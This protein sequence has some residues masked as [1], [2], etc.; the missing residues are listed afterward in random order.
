MINPLFRPYVPYKSWVAGAEL[1]NELEIINIRSAISNP[2]GTLLLVIKL[3]KLVESTIA[4]Q[5][6]PSTPMAIN[7]GTFTGS[8]TLPLTMKIVVNAPVNP[9]NFPKNFSVR[10]SCIS[11]S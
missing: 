8:V 9:I 7:F 11:Q 2:S 3:L 1:N 5:A 10:T 4:M 6:V